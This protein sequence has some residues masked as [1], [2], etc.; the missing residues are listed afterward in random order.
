MGGRGSIAIDFV[1]GS[2]KEVSGVILSN[3][4]DIAEEN[5]RALPVNI[6]FAPLIQLER[7]TTVLRSI[8]KN[9]EQIEKTVQNIK[10]QYVTSIFYVP[11]NVGS[12]EESIILLDDI[13]TQP[14]HDFLGRSRTSLFTLNQYAFYI[15]LIKLSIH[16]SR[17]GRRRPEVR[18]RRS[19]SA[20]G[21][22][23]RSADAMS[24]ARGCALS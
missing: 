6:L 22:L 7:Y 18:K 3:S 15:F 9:D 5:E 11:Q 2:R 1:T 8:G 12:I 4:C 21:E 19:Y 20:D 13:H 24:H 23:S 10:K 16:F 14:L 17:F